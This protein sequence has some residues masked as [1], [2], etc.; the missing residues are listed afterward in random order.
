MNDHK[1]TA[2]VTGCGTGIGAATAAVFARSGMHVIGVDMPGSDIA[3]MPN[4]RQLICA[5]LSTPDGV[6]HAASEID[7]EVDILVNNAGVA[8]TRSWREVLSVNTLAPRDLTRLLAPKFGKNPSV[9]SV[10]SQA[11]YAWRANYSRAQAF[12]AHGDWDT[13]LASLS[14]VPDIQKISYQISKE[15]VVVDM[16]GLVTEHR[17]AGLRANTVSPGTVET[18]LLKDFAVSMGEDVIEGARNWSGRDAEAEE[19]AEVIAFLVSPKASWV[20]GVDLAVDGGY[21]AHV[22]QLMN[23]ASEGVRR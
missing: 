21:S 8:A 13:A 2:V 10:A 11:G 5:D 16:L 6:R 15:A 14:E 18:P 20:N 12:L 7:A 4:V 19:V 22:F 3:G 17:A 9:V 23:A 1:R